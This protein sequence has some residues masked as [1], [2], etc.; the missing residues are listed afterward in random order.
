MTADTKRS[1]PRVILAVLSLGAVAYALVGAVVIPALPTIQ[2]DLHTSETGVTWVLTAYLLAASVGTSILGRLGD[3]HGK[4]HILLWA[5]LILGVGT[6]IAALSHSLP[7][8]IVGRALQGAAG[9]IFPLAFGI[10]RDEFPRERVA[11][12]IGLLSAILGVGSGLGIVGSGLIVK[13]LNWHWLFWI[14]LA[15]TVVAAY[16]TWRFIPESPVR[17]PGKINWTAATLMTISMSAIL[18][19]ISETTT[20]GWGSPKTLGLLTA[21]V[22]V[23]ACWIAVEVRS[24]TPLIDMTMMRIRGVW[25][26]NAAA[27]LLGAGMYSAFIIIP[28]FAELPTSTGFGFGSSVVVA[29]LYLLPSTIG[30]MVMS[31]QAGRLAAR[32][33]SR[34]SL[35]CGAAI[36]AGAFGLLVVAHSHPYDLL[37]SSTLMGMGM[38]LAFAA[39][40]NIVVGAVPP[41]QTGVASGMN[42]VM[43]TLGGALG[44]Q[45]AATLIADHTV[46][47]LPAVTGF[48]QSFALATV[49]L[50]LSLGAAILVPR[51]AATE[52]L[53]LAAVAA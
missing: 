40:G 19:A 41:Q 32:Y 34:V 17:A 46:D 10:V 38:G 22:A 16:F 49:F 39:L 25:T 51:T 29:G 21:G 2:H 23:G 52:P 7:M 18:L 53:E 12:S 4:E 30:M 43:R 5:L 9:G 36:T 26:A 33:G 28:Q 1:N 6:L 35:I 48:T 14:P 3:I 42:T 50:L 37:I 11:G 8:L 47:G 44:G 15:L 13:Y 27:F 31:L 20:W 24:A 45:I